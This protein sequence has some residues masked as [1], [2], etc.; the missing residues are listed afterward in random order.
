MVKQGLVWTEIE[1][2][3]QKCVWPLTVEFLPSSQPYVTVCGA[4]P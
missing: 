4:E 2:C 3:C 1:I